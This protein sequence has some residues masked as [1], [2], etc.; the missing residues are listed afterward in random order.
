MAGVE[1]E[2]QKIGC[3]G[4]EDSFSECAAKRISAESE[5]KLYNSFTQ[6]VD[7]LESGE[8]AGVVLP[9]E[10]SL[11]GGVFECLDL[12]ERRNI[13]A[14]RELLL[15]IDHRVAMLEGVEESAVKYVYSHEQA[16]AQCSQ[17]LVE[18][19]PNAQY[20]ST[21]A[22][23][24]SLNRLNAESAG[25]VGAHVKREGVVLSPENIADG[26]GNFTR[27]VLVKRGNTPP[28]HSVMVLLCAVCAHKP[29]SLLSLL[30]IFQRYELNLTRIESRPVKEAFGQYRFF[31]EFVGDIGSER[32]QKAIAE[33]RAFCTQFK[34]LGAYN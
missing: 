4:P 9:V 34:L 15:P 33:A 25:I 29:G 32:V 5:I 16:L 14:V 2:M 12:L 31:I 10:N 19:F 13:F 30:K 27:F 26:K 1:S 23:V 7:G 24:E 11:N 18:H 8:V 28:E 17:Y 21:S 3:L 22:T 20:C 6:A